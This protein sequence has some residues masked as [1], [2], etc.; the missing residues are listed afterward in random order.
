MAKYQTYQGNPEQKLM[1]ISSDFSGGLNL[2]F[3]DDLVADNEVRFIDNFDLDIKGQLKVR[4]GFGKHKALSEMLFS[5]TETINEF[6]IVEKTD[7]PVKEIAYIRLLRNDN[8][9]WKNLTVSKDLSEYQTYFGAESNVVKLFIL[10]KLADDSTKIFVNTY[11]IGSSSVTRAY[12]SKTIST[13]LTISDNLMNISSGEQYGKLYFTSNENGM[14]VYDSEKDEV[15]YVGTFTGKTNSAY[16]PTGIEARKIGF[17][18]LGTDPLSWTDNSGL[19]TESIQGVFI[20]T[21]DRIPTTVIPTGIPIQINIIH[22]G[23]LHDFSIVASEYESPIELAVSAKNATYSTDAISVYD[24]TFKTQPVNEVQFNINFTSEAVDLADYI[25]FY[26]IGQLPENAK[27]VQSLNVGA[28][29]IVQM[30]DRL[31]YY[32]DNEIWFSE[33]NTFDYIPNYNYI[34]VP[35]DADDKIV[36]IKFFRTSYMIFTRKKIFKLIGSFESSQLALELVNGDIGCI[37]GETVHL[38]ENDMYFLSTRGLRALKTDRFIANLENIREFDE[39]VYPIVTNNAKAYAIMYKDQYMLFSNL[40]DLVREVEIDGRT[41]KVPDVLRHYYKFSAFSMDNFAEESYP[42]F[43]FIEGGDMFSILGPE[44]FKFEEAY[45][46]FDVMY[47]AAI[48]T[49]G[50]HMGYPTHEK[51]FKNIIF[52]FGGDAEVNTIYVDSYADGN[53]EHSELVS[54][55]DTSEH[56]EVESARFAISKEYLPSKCKNVAIRLEI[57]AVRDLTLQAISYIFKLG[58]VKE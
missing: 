15:S 21:A 16:K 39:K 46:D 14:F 27:V 41:Y 56:L 49:A 10:A 11:T 36:K 17:N 4:K 22:T 34:L 25:D 28:Y 47:N 51:K 20:T 55:E 35:M 12:S 5:G 3:S 54:I 33:V 1:T 7:S 30:Y 9:A 42:R 13:T 58:K 40:R 8:N 24:V 37:A 2:M 19:T 48:E 50:T 23:D 31:V 29:N 43:I 45:S 52:K 26:P 57:P 53:L 32:K 44:V 38:V 6:P 18:V